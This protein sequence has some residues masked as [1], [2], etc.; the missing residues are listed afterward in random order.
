MRELRHPPTSDLD[1]TDV[2]AA[3]ADPVRL[4]AV[5]E[6]AARGEQSSGECSASCA[7][8]TAK[9]TMSHHFRVLREAGLTRTRLDG[10]HRYVTLRRADLDARF[11]GLLDAVLTNLRTDTPE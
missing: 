2:L 9:S 3:L 1:L 10:A 8:E 4:R 5:G 7:G 11:P 6:L